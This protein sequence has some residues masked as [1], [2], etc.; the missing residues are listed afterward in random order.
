MRLKRIA[1]SKCDH[2]WQM[3]ESL[4]VFASVT[5]YD[6][7]CHCLLCF[8]TTKDSAPLLP[9]RLLWFSVSWVLVIHHHCQW[10]F[11]LIGLDCRHY[12]PPPSLQ[13][14]LISN[15]PY[16]LTCDPLE[17]VMFLFFRSIASLSAADHLVLV[18]QFQAEHC[19]KDSRHQ[20]TLWSFILRFLPPLRFRFPPRLSHRHWV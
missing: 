11:A 17:M 12:L 15:W 16:S 3:Q 8:E 5:L 18:T 4:S 14:R 10:I 13:P 20:P 6:A 7:V 1:L 19:W 2:D 9:P